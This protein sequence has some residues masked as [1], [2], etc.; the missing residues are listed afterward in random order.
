MLF[1][2]PCMH[3]QFFCWIERTFPSE[4]S[5][6]CCGTT[7]EGWFRVSCA[8]EILLC[9]NVSFQAGGGNRPAS[10]AT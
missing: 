9:A 6:R 3:T 1:E 5:R 10:A 2:L 8:G 7:I 4:A